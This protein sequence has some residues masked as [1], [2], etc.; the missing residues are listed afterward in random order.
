VAVVAAVM[1]VKIVRQVSRWQT[2]QLSA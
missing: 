2:E 1:L